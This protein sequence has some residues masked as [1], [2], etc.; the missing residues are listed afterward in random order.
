M[1]IS[2]GYRTIQTLKPSAP[3]TLA[4]SDLHLGRDI[5]HAKN[6]EVIAPLVEGFERVLL[7][8]DIVDHWYTSTEQARDYEARIDGVCKKAGVREIIYFRGNH[9]AC[10]EQG[11]EF[12]LL[13]GVLY[14]HGHAV[15]HKLHGEG[16]AL[17]RIKALNEKKFGTHRVNSR[18]NQ[19]VWTFV[20]RMYGRIPMHL[21]MPFK[22]PVH[23]RKRIKALVD[24][25]APDGGVRAVVL[26][27]SHR[28]G[29]R[30]YRGMELFN[31]GGWIKNTRACGFARHGK[32]TQLVQIDMRGKIMRWGKVLF[33]GEI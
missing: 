21:M 14:L 27:H 20:E 30:H 28:P 12:A 13:D 19:K 16:E 33:D 3:N 26:G 5:T 22:F 8:G 29:V 23:V 7:L 1:R 15:Y 6:P 9:D 11:E 4:L 18:A 10:T 32:H 31:L 17:E 2:S 24:E 25:V